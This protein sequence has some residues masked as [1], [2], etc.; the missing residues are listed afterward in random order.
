M[1]KSLMILAVLQILPLACTP[2]SSVKLQEIFHFDTS[3]Y[4]HDVALEGSNVYVSDRQGGFLIF[5][6]ARGYRETRF[7]L[8]IRDVIS[9]SPN[10]GMPVLAARFEGLVLLSPSGQI[11]DSYSNGDI[12]NAVEVRG[13]F[14]FAAYGLHGLVV[15]RLGEGYV[16]LAATLP[17][18]GWSHDIRLSG[19][20]ALLADWDYGLR[21]VDIRNPEKPAEI[22][23]LRSPAT[24]I[25]LAVKESGDKRV[26]ALAEGNAGVGLA[27]LDSEGR[28]SLISRNSLGLNPAD[29]THPKAGGW[30]HSV[31]W[32][33]R[34]LFAANWKR[35]L[36]V[37]DALD[38][39]NPR[40]ILQVPTSGTALGVKTQR[41]SDGSYLIFLADGEFGLRIFRFRY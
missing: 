20:Q 14:A 31:A 6:R 3:G 35:G 9:L 32:A 10:S 29:P 5:D 16:R 33:D 17:T 4:S 13:N 23:S 15:A 1:Q 40:V 28:L 12:A 11:I 38:F 8:T 7:A 41:Q 18:K 26:L 27:L 24:C 30:V 2:R 22:S 25:S 34:Y 39:K 19:N 37:L 36:T 21:V